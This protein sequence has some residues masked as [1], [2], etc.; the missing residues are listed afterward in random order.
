MNLAIFGA[1]GS[2]GASTLDVVA[3]HPERYRVFA[4]TANRSVEPLAK[5]EATAVG[6]VAQRRT[7]DELHREVRLRAVAGVGRSRIVDLSDARMLQPAERL[8]FLCEAAQQLGAGQ[9]RLDDLQ[10]HRAA[11][12]ILLSL[13]DGA[14]AALTDQANDPV[15]AD[16]GGQRPVGDRHRF[17][18]RHR[19]IREGQRVRSNRGSIR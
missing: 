1:T 8:R 14:H 19:R 5:A 17:R 7:A 9:S 15:A 11:G 16:P 3:R 13:I 4:L 18:K 2:V 12:L 10:R 6:V